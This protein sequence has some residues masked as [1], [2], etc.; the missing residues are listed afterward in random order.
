L[1]LLRNIRFYILLLSGFI[2]EAVFLVYRSQGSS[3]TR[4]VDTY[5]VLAAS[6]LYLALVITP[7]TE[8][9]PKIPCKGQ[10]VKAR[11]ALG[12]SAFFFALVHVYFAFFKQLGGFAGLPY[13]SRTYLGAITVSTIALLILTTLAVTSSEYA[14][15]MLGFKNWKMLHR[16][17]Y[18]AAFFVIIHAVLLGSDFNTLSGSVA[19]L[20]FILVSI[21]GF[22]EAFRIDRGIAKKTGSPP[23]FGIAMILSA[24]LFTLLLAYFLPP[25]SSGTAS[26]H[27]YATAKQQIPVNQISA[28]IDLPSSVPAGASREVSFNLYFFGQTAAI[29]PD[30]LATMPTLAIA[31]KI[32][33]ATYK[34]TSFNFTLPALSA[35][36]ENLKLGLVLKDGSGQTIQ[37]PV[38]IKTP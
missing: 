5:A 20:S 33:A 23:P 31:N 21:L 30:D 29:T 1:G 38:D 7:V 12:V 17:V 6:F 32:V 15:K 36:Q 10:L 27:G 34:G 3:V 8:F 9:F 22:F 16:L 18:L 14:L 11:R 4:I 13:L 35:G 26:I 19:K 37:F 24:S 25:N 28:V 2:A